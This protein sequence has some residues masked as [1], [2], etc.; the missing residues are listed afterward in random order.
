MLGSRQLTWSDYVSIARRRW[1]V[2]VIPTIL[3]PILAYVGSL[4]IPNRYTS[5]TSVLVEE[6]KV[7]DTFVKPVVAEEVN[8]RLATM[9]EQIL[10]RTRLQPIIERFGLYKND[11][12]KKAME[13]LLDR[14][15]KSISVSPV[16]ADFGDSR[17]GGLPGFYISFTADD[18]KTAQQVCSEITSMFVNEN[19]RLREQHAQG[20]TDFL[21]SQVEEA[22][23]TLD[24]QDSRLAAFQSKYLN[25][26]PGDE[27]TNI[28]MLNSLNNRLEAINQ[29]LAQQ[30]QQKTFLEGMLARQTAEWKSSQVEGSVG[31]PVDLEKK[32][33]DLQAH[34]LDL[35]TRYTDDYP[36]VI[37][38]KTLLAELDKKIAASNAAASSDPKASAASSS[39][40]EPKELVQ[41]RLSLKQND[42]AIKDK[43]EQQE[44]AQKDI[45]IY[46]G[47]ISTSPRVEEEYKALTR[48]HQSAQAFYENLLNKQRESE[49]ATD[50]ERR[51][52]GEQFRVL[53]PPSLPERPTFPNRWAISLGGLAF[54]FCLGGG[55]VL[56]LEAKDQSL[57]TEPDV[58]AI[59]K[60]PVLVSVPII[61]D[62]EPQAARSGKTKA[63]VNA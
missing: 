35:Q 25:Q 50:L 60:L 18:P 3:M 40:T 5:K 30:Q 56:A 28:A 61:E 42:Q 48:D 37:K 9:Q 6:Q 12:G 13:D 44:Q 2:I 20:T 23:R 51:Q 47:R 24:E 17:S 38:T 26:L 53:D 49:M 10:S 36:D 59:L 54:G 34:L 45:R 1:W 57:R 55:L 41:L 58:L 8:Q 46:Q 7:P 33:T 16:K 22:K 19:L 63:L 21:K 15:R 29:A 62:A 14:M 4:W 43:L 27:Q 31:A 52:E 39:V 32:R 11:I